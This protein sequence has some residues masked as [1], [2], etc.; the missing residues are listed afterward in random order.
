MVEKAKDLQDQANNINAKAKPCL[1]K[2]TAEKGLCTFFIIFFS[3]CPP[4]CQ[5]PEITNVM[6]NE[7]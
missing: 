2:P 4:S 6:V 5:N 1:R 3:I 7:I